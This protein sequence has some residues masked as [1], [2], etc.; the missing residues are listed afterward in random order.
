MPVLES[1]NGATSNHAVTA[2]LEGSPGDRVGSVDVIDGGTGYTTSPTVTITGGGGTGATAAAT[3]LSG[4]ITAIIVSAKGTGYTTVPT[5]TITGGGGTGATAKAVHE[6]TPRLIPMPARS[7][8]MGKFQRI[9]S[10]GTTGNA[11]FALQG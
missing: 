8:R 1:M 5:V 2:V 4:V 10:T 3:V 7:F 9:F 11:W 6:A